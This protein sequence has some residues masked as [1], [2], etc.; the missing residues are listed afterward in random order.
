MTE[1]VTDR[2][3]GKKGGFAFVTFDD[4]DS[5]DRTAAQEHR[6]VSGHNCDIRKA[7]SNQEMASASSS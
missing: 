6:A 2:G 4:H 7:P 1:I 5:T 3:G